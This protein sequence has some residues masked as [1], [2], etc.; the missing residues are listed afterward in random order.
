V[1]CSAHR[2]AFLWAL[3]SIPG[4][5]LGSGNSPSDSTV[6]VARRGWHVD[7]GLAVEELTPALKS[8]AAQL[9][10]TRYAFF[11][12]ADKHY[13]LAAKRNAP[14]LL[15][16]LLPGAGIILLTGLANSPQQAFGEKQVIALRLD[17]GEMAALQFFV[18]TSLRSQGG[19][20]DV[21]QKGPYEDSAYFL[22]TQKYSALHTCNTWAAEALRAAGFRVHTRGVIFA[23][24]LWTQALRVQNGQAAPLRG[25]GAS[26]LIDAS[27]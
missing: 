26:L 15:G 5:A 24:Q 11:G 16:A 13:L 22:A 10:A 2:A 9:P 6:F 25:Q 18:W 8:V 19:S 3:L 23:R 14:V 21:Y 12:F 1:R 27:P 20:I 4:A 17:A 7:I